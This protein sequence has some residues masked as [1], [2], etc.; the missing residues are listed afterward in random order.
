[1]NL[2]TDLLCLVRF[3]PG[4][5]S[6]FLRIVFLNPR[7]FGCFRRAIVKTPKAKANEAAA[8]KSR[9]DSTICL[10]DAF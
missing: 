1:M 4:A 10:A 6:T 3:Q 8:I 9:Y 7:N 5:R 2:V